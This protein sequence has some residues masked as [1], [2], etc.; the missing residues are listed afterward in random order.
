MFIYNTIIISIITYSS[1]I[2]LRKIR[3]EQILRITNYK[4]NSREDRPEDQELKLYDTF[5]S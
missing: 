3:A 1:K 2:W 4:C 5:D